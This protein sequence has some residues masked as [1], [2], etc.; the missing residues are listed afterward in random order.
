MNKP[1]RFKAL[2][3]ST[4]SY[5]RI[6]QLT[7]NLLYSSSQ[8]KSTSPSGITKLRQST[9]LTNAPQPDPMNL[10]EFILPASI[11]SPAGMSPSPPRDKPSASV[12]TIASAIPIKTRKDLQGQMHSTFPP[13]SVPIPQDR[14]RNQEFDY[15]QRHVRKTSIDE[16]KVPHLGDCLVGT[17]MNLCRL[18]NDL[19]SSPHKCQQSTA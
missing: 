1:G 18:V 16:R 6:R 14:R 8:P 4:L 17:L 3:A 2:S 9:D 10:D 11:A 5:C 15:V 13:A 12:N 7:R 19:P